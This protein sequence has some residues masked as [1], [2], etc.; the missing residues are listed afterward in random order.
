[1]FLKKEERCLPHAYAT[2]PPTK[3]LSVMAEPL[4]EEQALWSLSFYEFPSRAFR[5]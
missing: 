3:A 1:M 2:R 5:G 4:L